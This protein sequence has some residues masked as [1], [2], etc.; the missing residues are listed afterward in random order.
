MMI[1]LFYLDVLWGR[2]KAFTSEFLSNSF[3]SPRFRYMYYTTKY[4][5][6]HQFLNQRIDEVLYDYVH[7]LNLE[8]PLYIQQ[9]L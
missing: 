1:Y 6:E 4:K 3:L 8:Y 7:F 2:T 5:L 9:T